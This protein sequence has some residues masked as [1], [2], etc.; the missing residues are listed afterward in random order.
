M[1]AT[2]PVGVPY[3]VG[4]REAQ[5]VDNIHSVGLSVDPHHIHRTPTTLQPTG[6]VYKQDPPTG[7]RVGKGNFVDIWVSTGKPKTTVPDVRGDTQADAVAALVSAHLKADVHQINSNKPANTVIAQ[8]PPP[9]TTVAQQTKVR[10]NVSSGPKPVGVPS[11]VGAS[12]ESA[13]SVLQ[14]QGFAVARVD[15]D[16]NQPADTVIK[17]DPAANSFVAPGSKITLT[18][19]KGP[20]TQAVPNV[21][22][23]D[24]GS[25]QSTL[26][27]A[28]FKSRVV[29]QDTQDPSLDNVV[30]TQD[31][32]AGT[33]AKP[34][35]T[36]TLTVGRYTGGTTTNAPP[37]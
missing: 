25:A 22:G 1:N 28:S 21:E 19:S 26:T 9:N 23:S 31:P 34:Q 14:G 33:Q 5:A 6:F 30:I 7:D 16:S 29:Y 20:A 18:V 2:K 10:I 36:V 37:P 12:Y 3:L 15:M 32:A 11:V 27:A 4:L 24:V 13:A 8:D 17:Q 35:T